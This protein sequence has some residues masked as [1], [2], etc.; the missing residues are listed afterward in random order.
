MNE[1]RVLAHVA[2]EPGCTAAEISQFLRINKAVISRSL[3]S[4]IEKSLVGIDA[5]DGARR[6]YITEDGA[7]QHDA[8]LPVAYRREQI[9][10]TGLDET[11]R[12]VLMSMLRRMHSNLAAMNEFDHGA[13]ERASTDETRGDE[14]PLTR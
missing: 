3:K 8:I 10:L 14:G 2:N 11:E 5:G 7:T 12:E 1:W 13:E 6:I 4:L 9:L